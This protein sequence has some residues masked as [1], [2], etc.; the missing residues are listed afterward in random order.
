MIKDFYKTVRTSKVV[1]RSCAESANEAR[2]EREAQLEEKR[3]KRIEKR[4]ARKIRKAARKA[5]STAAEKEAEIEK[6]NKIPSKAQTCASCGKS[7][8]RLKICGG[9][10]TAKKNSE[11]W[12]NT[13]VDTDINVVYYCGVSCQTAHWATHRKKC[14]GRQRVGE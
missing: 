5:K 7:G 9:C 12:K 2:R 14:A 11:A 3:R 8:D 13:G 6:E 4:R 10:K 1:K